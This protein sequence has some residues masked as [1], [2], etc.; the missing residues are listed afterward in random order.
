MYC[1][2]CG[3]E[4]PSDALFCKKCGY[5]VSAENEKNVSNAPSQQESSQ[6]TAQNDASQKSRESDAAQP[7]KSVKNAVQ[8]KIQS[9]LSVLYWVRLSQLSFFF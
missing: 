6:V 4:L 2:K 8:K 3:M 7:I 5:R 1:S 9:E